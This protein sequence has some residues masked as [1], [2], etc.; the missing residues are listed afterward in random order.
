MYVCMCER[1]EVMHVDIMCVLLSFHSVPLIHF[2]FFTGQLHRT[3]TAKSSQL[4]KIKMKNELYKLKLL[5]SLF[6]HLISLT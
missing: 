1:E 3:T 2:D 4:T 5:L 6:S